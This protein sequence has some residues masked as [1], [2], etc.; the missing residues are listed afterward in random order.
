LRNTNSIVSKTRPPWNRVNAVQV[1]L[2]ELEHGEH[3]RIID[4]LRNYGHLA[5]RLTRRIQNKLPSCGAF[6]TIAT[7]R[8]VSLKRQFHNRSNHLI[9]NHTPKNEYNLTYHD[10]KK[11]NVFLELSTGTR[12]ATSMATV[13]HTSSIMR[14]EKGNMQNPV[15]NIEVKLESETTAG[16]SKSMTVKLSRITVSLIIT[17]MRN[18]HK[19]ASTFENLY[20][21]MSCTTSAQQYH[22]EESFCGTNRADATYAASESGHIRD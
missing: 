4:A 22:I 12:L 11:R 9:A 6:K 18:F 21:T 15:Q 16:V 1:H 5:A 17:S 10:A 7:K 14:N 19:N 3:A 8:I 13:R 20:C 2:Y